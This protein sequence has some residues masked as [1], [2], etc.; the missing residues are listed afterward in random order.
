[1]PIQSVTDASPSIESASLQ[2]FTNVPSFPGADH[3]VVIADCATLAA[4]VHASSADC[5]PGVLVRAGSRHQ[6]GN[7]ILLESSSG[8][9]AL[10]VAGRLPLLDR[11]GLA[12]LVPP[13]LASAELQDPRVTEA[14]WVGTDH[15]TATA[16]RIQAS[17]LASAPGSDLRPGRSLTYRVTVTSAHWLLYGVLALVLLLAACSLAVT[18]VDQ[19]FDRRRSLATLRALGTPLSLLR[20]VTMLEVGAPLLIATAFGALNG[21]IMGVVFSGLNG[22]SFVIP[23]FDVI[24]LPALVAA[25]WLIVTAIALAAL[26]RAAPQVPL[27]TG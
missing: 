22:N 15:S 8:S 14:L 10:T 5:R 20:R 25:A 2:G 7:P 27:R 16:L 21:T 17:L 19:I 12:A 9:V 11:A 26:G 13:S 23:W 3:G 1:M 18:V 6:V 24:V 4:V